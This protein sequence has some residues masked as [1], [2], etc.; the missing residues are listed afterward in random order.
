[1]EKNFLEISV[2]SISIKFP[3]QRYN[4]FGVI[5]NGLKVLA[6]KNKVINHLF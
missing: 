4:M 5:A 6:D 2:F 3:F 1:M